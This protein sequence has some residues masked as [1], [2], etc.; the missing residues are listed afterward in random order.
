M[1]KINIPDSV[2]T[3]C[4]LQCGLS[5]DYKP[6]LTCRF[7]ADPSTNP[8]FFSI[9]YDASSSNVLYNSKLYTLNERDTIML[10]YGGIHS[11]K[12]ESVPLEIVIGHT[13]DTSKLFIC[14]PVTSS[15][16]SPASGPLDI[17][18]NTYYNNRNTTS[19]QLNNFN[20]MDI[21]PKSSYMVHQGPY[22]GGTESDTY[23][24]F[25]QNQFK[26]SSETLSKVTGLPGVPVA[27]KAAICTTPYSNLRPNSSTLVQN[28]KGTMSNGFSGD[29]QIYIDCQPTDSDG[30]IVVKET[31]V[32]ASAVK[33]DMSGLIYFVII[34]ISCILLV[35]LYQKISELFTFTPK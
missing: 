12:G 1:A 24:V 10:I 23:I 27:G 18:I 4:T 2:P 33:F 31:I 7:S 9:T 19:L 26:L 29:G 8:T 16:F 35:V 32:P 15:P 25:P 21:I 3:K 13:S 34:V 17:I 20:L 14:I 6:A 30:E 11:F 5:Y 22:L 28:E